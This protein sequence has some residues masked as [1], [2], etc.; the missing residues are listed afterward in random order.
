MNH[1]GHD[2]SSKLREV[3]QR[4]EELNDAR[5]I[6]GLRD[7]L[8][9]AVQ[10]LNMSEIAILEEFLAEYTG[11]SQRTISTMVKEARNYVPGYGYLHNVD[12]AVKAYSEW[13]RQEY[14]VIVSC[15]SGLHVYERASGSFEFTG[16]DS[17]RSRLISWQRSALTR[18]FSV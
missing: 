5:D 1:D 14:E 15:G 11:L 7:I 3:I 6:N 9:D 17:T 4:I 8:K 16:L 2:K 13:L 10:M 18:F 12:D